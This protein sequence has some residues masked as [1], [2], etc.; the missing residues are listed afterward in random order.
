MCQFCAPLCAT[1][2]DH[3]H[4]IQG[5]APIGCLSSCATRCEKNDEANQPYAAQSH[6]NTLVVTGIADSN[7][8]NP[9]A[10][11]PRKHGVGKATALTE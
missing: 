4:S 11:N 1:V 6:A 5:H 3:G 7:G 10:H 2:G 8:A 9:Y